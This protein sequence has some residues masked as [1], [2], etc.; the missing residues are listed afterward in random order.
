MTELSVA[1]FKAYFRAVHGHDPFPWQRRLLELVAAEGRWPKL[2]DLP[3]GSGKTAA[4]DVALFHL[5]LDA[6]KQAPERRAPRRILLVVDRR[7]VVEQGF[8]RARKIAGT[9]ASSNDP[10]LARVTAALRTLSQATHPFAIA[11]LRGGMPR[12][13]TWARWPDQPVVAISTVDQVGSR[14]LFRGY[15]VS[16]GMAPIHA[17]LL[18]ND[19][20]LLLDEVHLSEPF[21][22]TLRAVEMYR[23]WADAPLPDRFQVVELSATPDRS[24]GVEA[25]PGAAK[26]DRLRLE[27]DDR[28]HPVLAARLSASKPATVPDAVKVSGSEAQRCATFAEACADRAAGLSGPGR[29]IGVVVNRVAA[30]RE[31]IAC[32]ETRRGKDLPSDTRLILVTGRMRPLDRDALDAELR[33]LVGAGRARAVEGPPVIVVSTQ[34]I[35]A[36][37][38]FDFDAIVTECAALDALRQRF[39]RVDRL[40]HM[41]DLQPSPA[42]ERGVVLIRSDALGKDGRDPIYGDRMA[43]TWAWLRETER[44]FGIDAMEPALAE[45]ASRVDET[46]D[47]PLDG[48]V[49]RLAPKRRAPV[50]LPAHLDF[51]VQTKPGPTPDPDVALWLHGIGESQQPEVQ[52]VWR[53]DLSEALLRAAAPVEHEDTRAGRAREELLEAVLRRVQVCP[54]VGL[55]AIAVPIHAA[56]AWLRGEEGSDVAD[57]EADTRSSKERE[58]DEQRLEREP[59]R[60]RPAV[61]WLGDESRIALPGDLFPGC[62]LVVPSTYGGLGRRTWDPTAKEPVLDLGDAARWTQTRRPVLRLHPSLS[63]GGRWAK[64]PASATEVDDPDAEDQRAAMDAVAAMLDAAD[65]PAWLRDAE[66]ALRAKGSRMPEVVRIEDSAFGDDRGKSQEEPGYLALVARVIVRK[67]AAGDGAGSDVSTEGEDG[68]HT[69]VEVAL[70]S[71]LKGVAGL[72][73]D[74]AKRCGLPEP[75]ARS[76]EAAAAWHDAGKVDP[77]FQRLLRG[78]G[79]AL[80]PALAKSRTVAANRTARRRAQERSGYPKGARHELASVALLQKAQ[81]WPLAP[82]VDRDLVLH[83]IASHH[84]W[85][86][87]F[88]P[89]VEDATPVELRFEQDDCVAAA[90][91]AHGLERLDSGIAERFFQLVGRY[92]W[93][94]LAWLEAI[95]RLADHRRSEIE[96]RE[97]GKEDA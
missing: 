81:P 31:A 93:F 63:E 89:V 56:R 67:G 95:L 39:G 24:R 16:R 42:R 3:T 30:A 47:G 69:G 86:R 52:I 8:D 41:R 77:R 32:L 54:P 10:V 70:A 7:T 60:G 5:A 45:L 94:G 18:G 2:L 96:V 61:L 66:K 84:G 91:S 1:D 38:D 53:A 15:G 37:A 35:E 51:W 19:T 27:E 59:K 34:C 90:T 48:L 82:D 43:R 72:S 55:E 76:I 78:G 20:L 29:A 13:D 40:G 68:S 26:V 75:V 46:E 83:L 73:Y 6:Q 65:G 12:D 85:C 50:M 64:A 33:A 79:E 97:A 57:V 74:L 4:I 92:G 88:A 80:G 11:Q 9:L 71:H 23:G 22:Q 28:A 87:P 25:T 44:D 14:L 49:A 62:T 17:G 36:G 21:R 58:R